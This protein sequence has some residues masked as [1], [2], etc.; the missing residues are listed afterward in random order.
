MILRYCC[1]L[2]LL[3][4]LT[5]CSNREIYDS[6]QKRNEAECF[7]LPLAQQEECLK[8]VKYL[9]YDEYKREKELSDS[10]AQ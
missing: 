6:L 3:L 1:K 5:A 7:Q 4:L 2:L 10:S 9:E 8:Q